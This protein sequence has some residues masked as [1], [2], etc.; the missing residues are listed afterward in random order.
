GARQAPLHDTHQLQRVVPSCHDRAP[1]VEQQRARD[2][3]RE[4]P[5]DADAGREPVAEVLSGRLA[6]D[7]VAD[8]TEQE[9]LAEALVPLETET[10]SHAPVPKPLSAS[11]VGALTLR[12]GASPGTHE[13]SP[14]SSSR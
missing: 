1:P 7:G 8:I 5:A 2:V 14:A 13:S 6:D 12:K 9:E 11:A 10:T 4:L 3:G